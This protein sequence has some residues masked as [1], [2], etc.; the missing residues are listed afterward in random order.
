MDTGRSVAA[1]D[2]ISV[3]EKCRGCPGYKGPVQL[4]AVQCSVG[5]GAAIVCR[6]GYAVDEH[7][8]LKLEAQ[9]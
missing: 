7:C 1:A 3:A 6:H 4:A 5:I 2:L 8:A 9:R